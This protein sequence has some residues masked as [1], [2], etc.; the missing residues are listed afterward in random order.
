METISISKL[1]AHLSAEIKKVK[2]GSRI[3]IMDH[4]YPVA[5]LK[6]LGEE[7]TLF[8]REAKIE[9]RCEPLN[10]LTTQNPLDAVIEDREERW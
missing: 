8:V 3:V 1:K 7:E 4:N 6:P 2:S 9:Y 5:E 10:P